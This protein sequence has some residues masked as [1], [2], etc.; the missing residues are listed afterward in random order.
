M[1]SAAIIWAEDE[2]AAEGTAIEDPHGD[3]FFHYF[4]TTL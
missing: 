3:H 2:T 4:A 1:I